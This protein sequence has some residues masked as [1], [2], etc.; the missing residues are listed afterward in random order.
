MLQYFFIPGFRAKVKKPLNRVVS[1]MR[2]NVTCFVITLSLFYS[3]N[4]NDYKPECASES[5]INSVILGVESGYNSFVKALDENL[6]ETEFED[7]PFRSPPFH[8]LRSNDYYYYS[9]SDTDTTN[10]FVQRSVSNHK[11]INRI[12][13]G[14]GTSLYKIDSESELFT[15]SFFSAEEL[16]VM[17]DAVIDRNVDFITHTTY[18]DENRYFGIVYNRTS[19][20]FIFKSI[21][22]F[23]ITID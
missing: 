1:V 22:A 14:K 19:F 5:E 7:S 10:S 15:S 13:L 21:A 3:C 12:S 4:I 23:N 6:N 17:N 9:Y 2:S 16:V 8:I 18:R 20:Q 11:I